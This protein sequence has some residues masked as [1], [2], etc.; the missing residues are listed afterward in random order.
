[1]IDIHA[2][3]WN[4]NPIARKKPEKQKLQNKK[5]TITFFFFIP[6]LKKKRITRY[7]LSYLYCWIKVCNYLYYFYW[8]KIFPETGLLSF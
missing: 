3:M 1:M 6:D 5:I 7:T 2:Q 8:A 4:M